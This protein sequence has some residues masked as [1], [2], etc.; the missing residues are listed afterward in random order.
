[1][2]PFWTILKTI[3]L[4]ILVIL[5]A[6]FLLKLM[7]KQIDNK[8]KNMIIIERLQLS[9]TDSLNIVKI[10]DE[11]YLISHSD[12]NIDLLKTLDGKEV[13]KMMVEDKDE[14]GNKPSVEAFLNILKRS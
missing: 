3:L 13:E 2:E 4:L 14:D 1:M 11:Y 12:K 6:N 5:L 8:N 10:L 9:N 7:K